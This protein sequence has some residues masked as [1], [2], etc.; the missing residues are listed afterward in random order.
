MFGIFSIVAI[1]ANAILSLITFKIGTL[2]VKHR[3]LL[4]Y[5]GIEKF[6]SNN[7]IENMSKTDNTVAYLLT[8]TGRLMQFTAIMYVLISVVMSLG[9]HR[10]FS[11]F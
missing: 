3:D 11:S 2:F 10:N 8:S 7:Y 4:A 5:I 1:I 6:K 9:I